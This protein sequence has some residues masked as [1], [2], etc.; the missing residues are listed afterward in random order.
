MRK[1]L[2]AVAAAG[3]ISFASSA[4]AQ[5]PVPQAPVPMAAPAPVVQSAPMYQNA[6][7]TRT[8]RSNRRGGLLS[9]LVDLE[10]RKNAWLRRTFLGR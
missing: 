6:R 4:D 2:V 7:S 5:E 8:V 3:M 10:R 9:G 1:F